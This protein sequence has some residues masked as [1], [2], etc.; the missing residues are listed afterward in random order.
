L[1]TKKLSKRTEATNSSSLPVLRFTDLNL[2]SMA[3]IYL[4]AKIALTDFRSPR[5]AAKKFQKSPDLPHFR[6]KT[7]YFIKKKCA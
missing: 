5:L 7:C 1:K 4:P 6:N 3:L 2:T